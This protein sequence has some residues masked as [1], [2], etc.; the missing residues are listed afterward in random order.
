M[1]KIR[2]HPGYMSA[3]HKML[4]KMKLTAFLILCMFLGSVASE[5]YSQETKLT[6]NP[7]CRF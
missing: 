6:I 3:V 4:L 7:H 1:K 2:V 5:S